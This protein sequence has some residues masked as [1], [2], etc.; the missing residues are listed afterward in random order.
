MRREDGIGQTA[1]AAVLRE[2]LGAKGIGPIIGQ[3]PALQG[4]GHG[5]LVHQRTAGG[6]QQDHAGLCLGQCP[7]IDEPPGS[8]R[9][10]TMQ[11]EHIAA[12]Q[13]G[14]NVHKLHPVLCV[15]RTHGAGAHQHLHAKGA[16]DAGSL[17]ADAAVAVHA[18]GF[19]QQLHLGQQAIFRRDVQLPMTRFHGAV[20]ALSTLADGQQQT[21]G[22]L[23]HTVGGVA[24]HVGHGHA[25]AAAGFQVQIVG[26]CGDDAHPFQVGALGQNAFVDAALV[27][28]HQIGVPDAGR[29]LLIGGAHI[30][31][32]VGHQ[33]LHTGPVQVARLHHIAFQNDCFHGSSSLFHTLVVMPGT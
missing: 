33:R 19:V 32:G 20:V 30:A 2:R 15:L 18:K 27:Q 23:R 11:A 13:Q 12:G 9:G 3:L 17:A 4:I 8:G 29:D 16:G 26:A 1:Q 10:R 22:H 24:R 5:F 25:M 28:Q 6:V 31:H 7:G 21:E 14:V